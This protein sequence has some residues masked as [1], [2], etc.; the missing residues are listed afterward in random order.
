MYKLRQLQ[1]ERTKP[2]GIADYTM[3]SRIKPSISLT[4]SCTS[5]QGKR[6]RTPSAGAQFTLAV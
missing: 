5:D 2:S 1:H 4:D 3:R 6:A